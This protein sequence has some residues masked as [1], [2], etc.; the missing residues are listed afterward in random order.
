MA[1]TEKLYRRLTRATPSIASYN[2]LWLGPDHLL[3]LNSTGYNETYRRIQFRDIQ[4]FFT[5]E[6]ERRGTWALV[7]GVFAGISAFV[8]LASLITGRAPVFSAIFTGLGFVALIWNHLLGPGCRVH[9]ITGVQTLRLPSLVRTKKARR[10]LGKLAPLIEAA[11]RDLQVPVTSTP[12]V[13]ENLPAE[14]PIAP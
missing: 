8:L 1:K 14:P 2:S 12:P 7:W 5:V 6:S 9:V 13:E 3:V 4:A 10:V 11:Q